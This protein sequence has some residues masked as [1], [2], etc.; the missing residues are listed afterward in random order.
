VAVDDSNNIVRLAALA[1]AQEAVAS[2]ED[3]MA[4]EFAERHGDALRYVAGWGKWM[5]F[6]GVRWQPDS[7]LHAFDHARKICREAADAT[8]KPALKSART[9]AAVEK[10][11]RSDRR[12]AATTDQ[13]DVAPMLL[14]AGDVTFNLTT[15]DGCNPDPFDYGTKRAGCAA[16]PPGTPHPVWTAFLNRVLPDHELQRFLQRYLGYCCTGLTQEHAFVFAYGTGANGK[17]TFINTIAK[18]FGNYATTAAMETFIHSPN[19]RHPTDLA[20]LYG[21]RLV[22]ALETQKGRRWDETKIKALTGG[23]RITAR[24]MRQD[25]FDFTPTFKLLI[26]GNHRPRL[27]SV[28]EAMRRRLLLVPFT[29][30]IPAPE[31]DKGLLNKLEPE[32]PAILRWCIGGCQQW[33]GTGLT[34]PAS[35]IEATD[36]YFADQDTIGQWLEECTYD[37][38]PMAFTRSSVLFGSW[39]TWC[40]ER[41]LTVGSTGSLIGT[42]EERGYARKREGGTGQKGLAR[43]TVKKM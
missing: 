11:A 19:E 28:D 6:D 32:H 3:A 12:L 21:A 4:L 38:G 15:G 23:D 34:P 40:E 7:T 39:K 36:A 41:N 9:V 14:T 20:K 24:F 42:L 35:V 37:A 5:A 26:G 31:R 17:S 18:I 22:V 10:L 43:I 8:R 2:S 29:V 27:H 13:W 33:Q 16:A 1:D 30:Q 25:F